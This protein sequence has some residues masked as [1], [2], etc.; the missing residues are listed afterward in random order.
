MQRKLR[1][2]L[3]KKAYF[4]S[5]TVNRIMYGAFIYLFFFFQGM[6]NLFQGE[7]C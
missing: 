2:K 4:Y 6:Y 3:R 1:K 7:K 5:V